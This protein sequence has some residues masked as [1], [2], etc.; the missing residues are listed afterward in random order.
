MNIIKIKNFCLLLVASIA[1]TFCMSCG[2]D[3][4]EELIGNWTTLG[5]F[6]GSARG[7]ATGFVVGDTAYICLGYNSKATALN[8]LWRYNQADRTWKRR[9]DFPAEARYAAVSFSVGGK[10]YVGLGYDG[11]TIYNDFWEYDPKTNVWTKVLAEFPGIERYYAVGAAVGGKG[12]VG[13]GYDGGSTLKD[14]YS[15]TP[16][17]GPGEG[18]WA[19]VSSYE[20]SKREGASVFVIGNSLYLLGGTTNNTNP[21]DMQKYDPAT[22]KWTKVMDMK[23]TDLTDI[24]D[25]YDNI[26]RAYASTFVI[27]D[28]GYITLGQK[29]TSLYSTYEYDPSTNV[30]TERTLFSASHRSYAVSFSL[31]ESGTNK[32]KRGFVMTGRSGSSTRFD[33]FFEFFPNDVNNTY[34][35]Y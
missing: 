4:E 7:D 3:E 18:T 34:D 27:N 14:F 16:G 10:A 5:S 8:D 29:T 35:D 22:D 30:W 21:V 19:E 25:K 9:A 31:T 17:V 1:L 28:K 32:N 23:N 2:S 24:D 13:T 15:F 6:D 12:Y 33:D 26:P 11:R 20:G